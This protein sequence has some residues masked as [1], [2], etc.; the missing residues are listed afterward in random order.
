M[1]EQYK[2][3][4]NV[5]LKIGFLGGRKSRQSTQKLLLKV[6]VVI[7][8]KPLILRLSSA[9]LLCLQLQFKI[10]IK[11]EFKTGLLFLNV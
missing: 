2:L 4:S 9:L 11:S 1:L 10:E 5:K 7:E 8:N 6:Q 3:K